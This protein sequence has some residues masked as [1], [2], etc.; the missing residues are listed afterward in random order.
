VCGR[1]RVT[2]QG[3]AITDIHQTRDQL[4]GI[5]E[6]ATTIAPPLDAKVQDAL[7]ATAHVLLD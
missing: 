7:G 5:L 6:L 1:C 2:G 3:L 4:Q